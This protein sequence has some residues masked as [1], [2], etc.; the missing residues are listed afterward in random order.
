MGLLLTG[1]RTLRSLRLSG[2]MVGWQGAQ[3]LV[4]G[5]V[6]KSGTD[7]SPLHTLGL[8]DNPLGRAAVT[9]LLQSLEVCTNLV[10][11]NLS[12]SSL[13]RRSGE[14][15][16]LDPARPNGTYNLDLSKNE[17]RDIAVTLVAVWLAS[18]G[19]S[20]AQCL[21]NG[22]PFTLQL[23]HKWPKEMPREGLLRVVVVNG[24]MV[25]PGSPVMCETML[26][27]LDRQLQDGQCSDMWRAELLS[28]C[29][30]VAALSSAQAAQLLRH[31]SYRV[32]KVDAAAILLSSIV[33]LQVGAVPTC[34][35]GGCMV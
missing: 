7:I 24:C 19:S 9:T 18:A 22:A 2:N 34:R 30:N 31:F 14:P 20:W 28:I 10:G 26:S 4:Q 3:H 33:D 32:E 15:L 27:Y 29:T 35:G 8:D 17:D 11:L 16:T 25:D 1:N 13:H 6:D 23:D 12:N 5:L 21:F